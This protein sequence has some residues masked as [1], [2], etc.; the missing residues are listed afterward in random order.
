MNAP[1]APVGVGVGIGVDALK[2]RLNQEDG[3]S[4]RVEGSGW[5][6]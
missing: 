1:R 6:V 3:L 4:W 5:Y 2:L